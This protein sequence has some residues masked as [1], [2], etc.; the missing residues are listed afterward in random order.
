MPMLNN[1]L[2]VAIRQFYKLPV[3]SAIN[4]VGLVIGL[5]SSLL[6]GLWVYDELTWDSYHENRENVY[7]VYLNRVDDNGIETQMAVCLPLWEEFEK[8][9][10][11]VEHV[12]PTNWG[13]NIQYGYKE[14]KIEKFTYFADADFLK[15][16]TVPVIKGSSQGLDDPKSI[17]MTESAAK[18]LFG[19][20]DPI[21][22]TVNINARQDELMTVT[23]IVE[24][25]PANSSMKFSCLIPFNY[26][27]QVDPWVQ[28]NLNY[29]L[30]NSFN[31]YLSLRPGADPAA[32]KERIR[33]IITQNTPGWNTKFEVTVLPMSRWHLYDK[34]ED[35]QSVAGQ[36]SYVRIFAATGLFI[37]L[38]ACINFMNLSTARSERRAK[39][40]GIRK[41]I[42][43]NRNQLIVQFLGETMLMSV[44]AFALSVVIVEAALPAFNTLFAKNLSMDYTSGFF[45]VSSISF[46][47]LTSLIAGAYPAF[48]LSSFRPA[49]VLKGRLSTGKSGFMPRRVLVTVQFFF[50]IVL[51]FATVVVYQ[52]MNF[53]KDRDLGYNKDN[54]VLIQIHHIEGNYK[55]FKNELLQRNY[56]TSV[57]R[58]NSPITNVYSMSADFY[59]P[60]KRE[61]QKNYFAIIEV[62]H[63]YLTTTETSLVQGRE[64]GPGFVDSLSVMLNEEAVKYMGLADP[65]GTTIKDDDDIYT[66]VGVVKNVIMAN[67]DEPVLPTL[68]LYGGDS[69]ISEAMVRLPE[70]KETEA[71]TGIASI[72]RQLAPEAIFHYRFADEEYGRKFAEIERIGKFTNIF[73]SMAIFVSCL[74]LFGLAAFTAERRT[75]EIGIRKVL[76]AS[77]SSLVALLSKE[78]AVLVIIAFV[79][80]GP[81]C[82]WQADRIL[83]QYA[84]HINIHWWVLPIT[85]LLALVL[86]VIAVGAQAFRAASSNPVNSLK[87]E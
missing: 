13:W 73:A 81:V 23:A 44:A 33:D 56:A 20:E 82:Y 39:E 86:A 6:I 19:D 79:M 29:W 1:Y 2:K 43:S 11:E 71:I 10:P 21:G 38:I 51:I 52:Q 50:S 27:A 85:G 22:K 68:Y 53:L 25:P 47:A 48:Y 16:F 9:A 87:T 69:H 84:Y 31:M 4:I 67:P 62:D 57:T 72:H 41:S 17:V 63:D 65:L 75:K 64:F 12:T 46:V 14:T 60:G 61:D 80:A 49:T 54:L 77:V 7:R 28:R 18:E 76:G 37:L 34:W 45:W 15:M 30:N 40:V 35:G 5:S 74:G 83:E 8:N 3:F 78:F 70:G 26:Y 59:W 24:D 66:V 36:L 58:A 42:G 55:A 32:F